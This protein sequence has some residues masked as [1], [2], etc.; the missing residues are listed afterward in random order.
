MS[1]PVDLIDRYPAVR[2][3]VQRRSYAL[4]DLQVRT[5]DGTTGRTLVGTV[6]PWGQE[7]RVGGY[8]EQ[9]ARGAFVGTDPAGVP[10]LVAHRHAS[11]PIGRAA[12]LVDEADRL[13]GV[14]TLSE[15]READEVLTLA[16]DGV[17]L[18]LSVGFAP[19]PGGDRWTT[20]RAAVVRTRARLAE[21]S[22][23]GVPAYPS[24]TVTGVRAATVRST[25][26]LDL[27]RLLG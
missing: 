15:T 21:V 17:P 13:A 25:P 9:F 11:L 23:V 19:A 5:D 24:A 6:V 22:V 20:D 7:I 27:A 12:E 18:G 2:A 16:A 14:F 3:G 1:A 26:L 8:R 10:L 4:A